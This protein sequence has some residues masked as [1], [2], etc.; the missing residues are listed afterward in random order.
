MRI[1]LILSGLLL[2]SC[3][4]TKIIN[5][6]SCIQK[7]TVKWQYVMPAHKVG[8]KIYSGPQYPSALIGTIALSHTPATEYSANFDIC[9][10]NYVSI[11][12]FDDYGNESPASPIT[13]VGTGCRVVQ[14]KKTQEPS[15]LSAP[16]IAI[17]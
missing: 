10:T 5:T 15:K 14:E 13:C 8:F 17:E 16:D 11:T 1:L 9:V 4:E 3:R 6:N 2:L 7:K 12:A